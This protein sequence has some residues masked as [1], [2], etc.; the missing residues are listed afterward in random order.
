MKSDREWWL[1][2]KRGVRFYPRYELYIVRPIVCSR[3]GSPNAES[4]CVYTFP[5]F[6][7]LKVSK[8]KRGTIK[9]T[10][11]GCVKNP[12]REKLPA[13][14]AKIHRKQVNQRVCGL[15]SC[16]VLHNRKVLLQVATSRLQ[17]LRLASGPGT[18]FS[19]L[20]CVRQQSC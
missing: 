7:K 2:N 20:V 3:S 18:R 6:E 4:E 1:Y 12:F 15:S 17:V 14:K 16:P 11:H 9:G 13:S 10:E 8:K 19:C 5:P